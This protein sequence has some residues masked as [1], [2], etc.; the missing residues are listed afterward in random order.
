MS[1]TA[2]SPGYM[3]LL[4]GST[5]AQVSRLEFFARGLVEGFIS[6]RHRSPHK[7]F[8]V[9]FAEHRQYAPGDDLHDLDWRVYGKSDRFYIKQYVEETNLRATILVDASG[10]MAYT[11]DAAA[12]IDGRKVSKFEYAQFLAAA[13]AYILVKQ[14]DAVGLVTFDTGLRR[15]IPA[16]SRASQLRQVLNELDQ[17][18]PGGETG[19]GGIF[20]NIADRIHRRGIVI[21]ISDL[22]DKSEEITRALHHFR[23]RRHEVLV[24]HVMAEEELTFPFKGS[25]RFHS[26]EK[27]D[28]NL[29]IDPYSIR[30]EY[31]ARIKSFVETI[32]TGCSQIKADYVPVCTKTPFHEALAD[33]LSRRRGSR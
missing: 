30:S 24:F 27:A 8:S 4:P 10:S 5:T 31:L 2:Q 23:Y 22:F 29:Q 18:K 21:I 16:R 14:Q 26:L 3:G 33:C 12:E 15:Y 20:H 13:L 32:K 25:T 1:E 7:G 6:G 17:T 19:L 11:G 9:E 28:V